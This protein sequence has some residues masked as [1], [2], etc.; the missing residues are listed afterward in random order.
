MVR[1][2]RQEIMKKLRFGDNIFTHFVNAA[3]SA[4]EFNPREPRREEKEK[5]KNLRGSISAFSSSPSSSPRA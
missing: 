2:E 5:P 4:A 3:T 1:G